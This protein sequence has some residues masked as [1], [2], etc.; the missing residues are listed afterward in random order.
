MSWA[1]LATNQAI[2][3][4]NLQ[5]AVD[6]GVFTLIS[7][8][9]PT[10][11]QS[12][13]DYVSTHVSGFNPNYPPY[14]VKANNQLI[15]KGDI[16]NTGTVT[17]SPQ[18]G[19]YFQSI[20]GSGTGF[21][22]FTYPVNYLQVVNYVNS[23]SSQYLYIYLD[24]VMYTSPLNLSVY[25]ND[26]LI[27]CQNIYSAGYQA[28]SILLPNAI[29]AP[30]TL[31]ITINSG[32][33]SVTPPPPNFTDMAFAA[34]A[35]S[36]VTGQ[37]QLLAQASVYNAS[38]GYIFKSSDYGVSWT[39]L[40]SLY[41][42][43]QKVAISGNGQYMLA[44]AYGNG[45]AWRSS[46]YGATWTQ[47]TNFPAPKSVYGAGNTITPLQAQNFYGAGISGNGANQC[48]VT[49]IT[50]FQDSASLT[51]KSLISV[52]W[53]S[54]DYGATWIQSPWQAMSRSIGYNGE[55]FNAV[56]ID[57]S[58]S[59]IYVAVGDIGGPYG[60][61]L[62]SADGGT[63]FSIATG[64]SNG[65]NINDISIIADGSVISATSYSSQNYSRVIYSNNYGVSFSMINHASPSGIDQDAWYRC[66]IFKYAS[67]VDVFATTNYANNVKYASNLLLSTPYMYNWV[68][69]L[70]KRF[71]SLSCSENGY[72]MIAATTQGVWKSV[73]FQAWV[74]L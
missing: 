51:G 65:A 41:N 28:L 13:K 15:V 27:S 26:V 4:A 53:I 10:S 7:S 30:S 38:Q 70:V 61:V 42:Y 37:Y 63:N 66:C 20:S 54:S 17:L 48:I 64:S 47:I 46:D 59:Y 73:N 49:A 11:Q 9:S 21:P 6:T 50:E 67:E 62:R 34:S 5:D 74:Q 45:A 8:I 16:Y 71:T 35:I 1:S 39:Q 56:T 57:S 22:T 32:A 29:N 33:C 19:M 18:Y 52:I 2:S 60:Y 14:A 23:I 40:S 24:G 72:Y 12:T 69:N 68:Q 31:Y 25:V 55:I 44:V 58:G 43:W 3:Y 36:R